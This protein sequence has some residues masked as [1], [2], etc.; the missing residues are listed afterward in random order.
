MGSS[1]PRVSVSRSE[2]YIQEQE[3]TAGNWVVERIT[4]GVVV[5]CNPGKSSFQVEITVEIASKSQSIPGNCLD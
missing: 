2:G 1:R 3:N 5:L 4:I